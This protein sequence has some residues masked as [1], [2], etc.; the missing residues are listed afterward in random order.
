MNSIPGNTTEY[1]FSFN[2]IRNSVKRN[3][4]L[5]TT[6][7]GISYNEIQLD[8]SYS[9]MAP[10]INLTTDSDKLTNFQ[11]DYRLRQTNEL[12]I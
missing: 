5:R 3:T 8:T 9:L 2:E 4:E 12:L 10:N 7:Y 11:S 1:G 6:E